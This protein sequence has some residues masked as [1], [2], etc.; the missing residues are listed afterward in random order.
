MCGGI[1]GYN[2]SSYPLV[3]INPMAMIY[4][5]Q[6]IEGFVCHPWLTGKQGNFL[7]DMNAWHREGKVTAEETFFDGLDKWPDAFKSLFSGAKL[8]KVVVR[9]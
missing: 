9:V 7:Q 3:S 1:S 2:E 5:A 6:R 8:G 4:T